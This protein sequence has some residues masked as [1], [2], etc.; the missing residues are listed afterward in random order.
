MGGGAA[1]STKFLGT[2]THS[3]DDRGRLAIPAKYRPGLAD[4]LVITRGFDPCLHIW[5]MDEWR[6]FSVRL[7]EL[8]L[9]H[10][11]IRR[12]QRLIFSAATD[13]TPDR[14][15][16]ILIP[17]YLRQYASLELNKAVLIVGDGNRAEVWSPEHWESERSTTERDAPKIAQQLAELGIQL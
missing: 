16:R 1:I 11:E 3:L 14:L 2:F 5:D 12:L 10:G 9:L 15:G 17:D 7:G 13:A 4:G 6:R 8:S